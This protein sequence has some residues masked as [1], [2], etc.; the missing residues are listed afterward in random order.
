MTSG[1]R[2]ASVFGGLP[3]NTVALH[4]APEIST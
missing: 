4:N 3:P 1:R 2:Y